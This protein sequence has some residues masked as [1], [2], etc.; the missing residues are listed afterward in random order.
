MLGVTITVA[1]VAVLIV[2]MTLALC[3]VAGDADRRMEEQ[4]K[5]WQAFRNNSEF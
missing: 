1:V 3:R 2:L 4:W 5:E